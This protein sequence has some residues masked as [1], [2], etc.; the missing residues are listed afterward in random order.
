MNKRGFIA[1]NFL[2]G[3]AGLFFLLIFCTVLIGFQNGIDDKEK[4]IEVFNNMQ[5]KYHQEF[6]PY[7]ISEN[8]Y[9]STITYSF[10]KIV[11]SM[12]DFVLYSTFEVTKLVVNFAYENQDIVNAQTLL[13]I[14]F[15][16]LIAPLIYP[17]FIIIVSLIMIFMEWRSKKREEKE[18]MDIKNEN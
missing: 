18:L 3:I 14:I 12:I 11:Y 8:D 1:Y 4:M 5:F 7:S 16:A 6:N 13:I 17:L 9:P 2:G 10:M 15:L